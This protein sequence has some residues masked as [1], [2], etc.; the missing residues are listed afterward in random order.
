MGRNVLNMLR[1]E[2]KADASIFKSQ[3]TREVKIY[4]NEV[5]HHDFKLAYSSVPFSLSRAAV[6]FFWLLDLVALMHL[7]SFGLLIKFS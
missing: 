2:V 5:F 6:A 3:R 1:L 4:L 7:L